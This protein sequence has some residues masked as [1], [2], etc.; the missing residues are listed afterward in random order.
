M[1]GVSFPHLALSLA[2]MAGVTYLIRVLPFALL[3]RTIR[4][5]F[6]R[7]LLAYLPYAVL[8]GMT[9]PSILYSTG[10]IPSALAGTA[11]AFVLAMNDRSLLTVALGACLASLAVTG[12]MAII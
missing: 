12:V 10:S 5:R 9:F 4:S 7:S 1:N 3:R 2:V 11:V 8:S 6:L